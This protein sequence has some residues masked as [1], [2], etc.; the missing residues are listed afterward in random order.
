MSTFSSIFTS[1]LTERLDYLPPPP[2]PVSLNPRGRWTR[3]GFRAAL[4]LVPNFLLWIGHNSGEDL[5]ELA[6]HG[7]STTG[8]IALRG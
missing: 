3:V 2:R 6:A 4:L 1:A 7:R 5:R 8:H